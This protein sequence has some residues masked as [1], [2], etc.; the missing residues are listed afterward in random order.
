M[1]R[2]RAALVLAL[3]VLAVVAVL[4][5]V[6]ADSVASASVY[7]NVSW[8]KVQRQIFGGAGADDGDP[9]PASPA[10]PCARLHLTDHGALTLALGG[11]FLCVDRSSRNARICPSLADAAQLFFVPCDGGF[12]LRLATTGQNADFL[13]AQTDGRL[14][15]VDASAAAAFDVAQ[16]ANTARANEV[17][18]A[19]L[20]VD[21][22]TGA[23]LAARASVVALGK[24]PVD[25]AFIVC[26]GPRT[27]AQLESD[28]AYA[29]LVRSQQ[30]IDGD[31]W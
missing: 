23:V 9:A 27:E 10:A 11:G 3:T 16:T 29:A 13:G 21:P 22:S 6:P 7:A 20:S 12:L 24:A 30:P 2:R 4:L 14:G 31:D 19:P 18:L 5:L 15:V 26:D 8:Q 25:P 1:P 28:A 17:R